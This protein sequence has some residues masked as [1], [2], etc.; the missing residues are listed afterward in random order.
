MPEI[1]TYTL[2]LSEIADVIIKTLDIH[3]GLWGVYL[4]F[5][6]GA[7]NIPANPEGKAI[8]PAIIGLV[9]KIGIQRFDSPNNLTVDAAR[10]NPLKTGKKRSI[11]TKAK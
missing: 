2:N 6:L 8:A 10:S 11:T 9:Q 4:E 3:E 7:A 5:G 1:K